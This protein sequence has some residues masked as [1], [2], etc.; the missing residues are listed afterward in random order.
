MTWKIKLGVG[1]Y[2][3]NF[4]NEESGLWVTYGGEEGDLVREPSR[5]D[6]GGARNYRLVMMEYTQYAKF[7]QL[8]N[9]EKDTMIAYY[10]LTGEWP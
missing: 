4:V 5:L 9:E 1:G 10:F 8:P 7:D 3:V 6:R 2:H